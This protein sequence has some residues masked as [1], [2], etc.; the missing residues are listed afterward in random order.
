MKLPLEDY[1]KVLG[2]LSELDRAGITTPRY[3][4]RSVQR[5][6][7]A[8]EAFRKAAEISPNLAEAALGASAFANSICQH[9]EE[10]LAR[11]K[12]A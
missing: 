7:L 8:A 10:A 2:R 12:N 4:W 9:A 5:F 11:S 6:E 3:A 1:G